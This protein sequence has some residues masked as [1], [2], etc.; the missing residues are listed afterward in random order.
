MVQLLLGD[1]EVG[2]IAVVDIHL[3]IQNG[4]DI[5]GKELHDLH[6]LAL[7]NAYGKDFRVVHEIPVILDDIAAEFFDVQRAVPQSPDKGLFM[8]PCPD[9][10]CCFQQPFHGAHTAPPFSALRRRSFSGRSETMTI[11]KIPSGSL[12]ERL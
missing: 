9:F 5:L 1:A 12:E 3:T 4:L 2:H 6:T 7:G 11:L 8:I 10:L